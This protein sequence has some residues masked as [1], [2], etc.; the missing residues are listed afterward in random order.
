M[1]SREK[2]RAQGKGPLMTIWDYLLYD[3]LFKVPPESTDAKKSNGK[4]KAN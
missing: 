4:A 1:L 2:L 3:Y